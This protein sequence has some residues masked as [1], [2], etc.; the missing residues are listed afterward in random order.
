MGATQSAKSASKHG[1]ET[2]TN[3]KRQN[4][5]N[6]MKI[7]SFAGVTQICVTAT[8]FAC[9][10]LEA[11]ATTRYVN[12]NDQTMY[13]TIMSAVAASSAGD[14]VLVYPG[15]YQESVSISGIILRALRGPEM[16]LIKAS[17]STGST[18]V[19]LAGRLNV[20]LIG[21]QVQGFVTGIYVNTSGTN[22]TRVANCIAAGNTGIGFYFGSSMP[23]GAQ[24]LNNI[25]AINGGDGFNS[26]KDALT[27]P[28][29]RNNI[30]YKNTGYGFSMLGNATGYYGDYNC[31]FGNNRAATYYCSI[32]NNS[33]KT[34]PLLDVTK[35]YRFT[36]QSSPCFAT[37]DPASIYNNPDNTHNN[38]G[39]YG[40]PD[41]ANWWLSPTGGPTV[42]NVTV[43]P[44]QVAPGGTVTIRATAT[45]Q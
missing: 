24:I 12:P 3:H 31:A 15:I 23:T 8:L 27:Y 18:G 40:G 22:L 28:G 14:M 10:A 39:A 32:G 17:A 5:E 2:V 29:V 37:G 43:V 45:S 26:P 13:Q 20:F 25:S 16:T 11:V 42:N 36:S 7:N 34:D 9:L 30:S 4:E 33:I 1:K 21:F 44:P 6:E 38:M 19:T 35:N 41:A